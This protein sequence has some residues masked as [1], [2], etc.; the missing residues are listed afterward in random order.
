MTQMF[1]PPYVVISER[2]I[3]EI[4]D[5]SANAGIGVDGFSLG[6]KSAGITFGRRG[7][8][9]N[10]HVL[11]E[12]VE[13][14]LHDEMGDLEQPGE[15]IGLRAAFQGWLFTSTEGAPSPVVWLTSKV[16]GNL[17]VLCGSARNVIGFE[18]PAQQQG[19][20][21]STMGGLR[22]FVSALR[23]KDP[24]KLL[25]LEA[26]TGLE[27]EIAVD[28]A[29]ISLGLDR[30][31]RP[32]IAELELDVL[33]KPYVYVEDFTQSYITGESA[34][35]ARVVVGAPLW[36]REATDVPPPGSK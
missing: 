36:A 22:E 20:R 15:F 18:A 3:Q 8:S 17:V 33:F 35:Y 16:D 7:S 29:Y 27:S 34:S 1:R 14:V 31:G 11:A 10:F 25:Q 2:M 12:R 32:D 9:G 21:P 24:A 5:R 28:A 6:I 4:V 23:P 19:W 30:A 26:S 13:E